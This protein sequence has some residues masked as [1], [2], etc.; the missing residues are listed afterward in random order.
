MSTLSNPFICHHSVFIP[1]ISALKFPFLISRFLPHFVRYAI[2]R[3]AQ[4]QHWSR[5]N[6]SMWLQKTLYTTQAFPSSTPDTLL[7]TV[8]WGSLISTSTNY[9]QRT[10]VWGSIPTGWPKQRPILLLWEPPAKCDPSG[11]QLLTEDSTVQSQTTCWEQAKTATNLWEELD[12]T[13][14][15]AQNEAKKTNKTGSLFTLRIINVL[16]GLPEVVTET[17]AMIIFNR[18]RFLLGENNMSFL[19]GHVANGLSSF[20]PDP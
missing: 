10:N 5:D 6:F 14:W 9:V 3:E 15:K 12:G 18:H 1:S 4:S 17:E 7:F 19:A 16:N 13:N 20:H 2:W 11:P 8:S